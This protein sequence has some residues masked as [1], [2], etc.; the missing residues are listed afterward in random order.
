MVRLLRDHH[1]ERI[2]RLLRGLRQDH[3]V[4]FKDHRRDIRLTRHSKHLMGFLHIKH[5]MALLRNRLNLEVLRNSSSGLRKRS[6]MRR[7][8]G[9][10]CRLNRLQVIFQARLRRSICRRQPMDVAAR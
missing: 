2:V 5:P 10:A 1:Q 9:E 7:L 3:T 6:I 4:D 8:T